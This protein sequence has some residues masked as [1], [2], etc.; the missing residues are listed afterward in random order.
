MASS[1]KGADDDVSKVELSCKSAG[2]MTTDNVNF[3]EVDGFLNDDVQVGL[4]NIKV[5][6]FSPWV[7]FVRFLQLWILFLTFL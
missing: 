2:K 3:D 6:L 4:K 7:F 5:S 1:G